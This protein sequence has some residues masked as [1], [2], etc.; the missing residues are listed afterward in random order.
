MKK[1]GSAQNPAFC[2]GLIGLVSLYLFKISKI[3]DGVCPKYVQFIT[4]RKHFFTKDK[5]Y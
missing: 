4:F 1:K 5:A 2:A 3:I